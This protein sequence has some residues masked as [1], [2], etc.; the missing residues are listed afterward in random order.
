MGYAEIRVY[1]YSKGLTAEA[2]QELVEKYAFT[3]HDFAD[4]TL[5]FGFEG[6]YFFI[7]DFLDELE[8]HLDPAAQ[9]TVDYI[10]QYAFTM[11]RHTR[12]NGVWQCKNIN[13]ND[14]LERYNHEF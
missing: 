13:L 11:Q 8:K 1:G 10:D 5:D 2:A 9:A 6:S 12:E 14:V 7:E 4:G 3:E